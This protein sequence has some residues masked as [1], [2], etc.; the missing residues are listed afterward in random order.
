MRADFLIVSASAALLLAASFLLV[1]CESPATSPDLEQKV[2]KLE[3]RV[4]KLENVSVSTERVRQLERRVAT[5]Q[6]A[7]KSIQIPNS[8]RADIN[9]QVAQVRASTPTPARPK[10]PML[11]RGTALGVGNSR[12]KTE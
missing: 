5:L 2:E 7:Q 4:A 3:R 8:K 10:R 9:S 12:K 6:A 11:A 1:A